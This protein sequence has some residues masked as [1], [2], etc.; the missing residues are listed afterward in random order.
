MKHEICQHCGYA[1]EAFGKELVTSSHGS[2]QFPAAPALAPAAGAELAVVD[3]LFYEDSAGAGHCL[4]CGAHC[5]AKW[6]SPYPSTMHAFFSGFVSLARGWNLLRARGKL[7]RRL[8]MPP[9]VALFSYF[10]ILLVGLKLLGGIAEQ[11]SAVSW[12]YFDWAR[13]AA[14]AGM[15]AAFTF[16]MCV[17][18]YLTFAPATMAI[19]GPFLDPVVKDVDRHVLGQAP[20]LSRGIVRDFWLSLS[21]ALGML[22]ISLGLTILALPLNL[23][24]ILGSLLYLAVV[25]SLTGLQCLDVPLGRRQLRFRD[26]L[27]LARANMG[28]T[29]GLGIA[30]Y[31]LF[32]VPIVGWLVG[33]QVSTAG[34]SLVAFR[35]R[36]G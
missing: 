29:L 34:A 3:A 19:A 25:A 13:P 4:V 10:L 8:I 36:K 32:L 1:W 23:V 15:G 20:E 11:L 30:C 17:F 31:L 27:A 33:P 35:L 6:L 26:R 24:P 2:R 22:A 12:G 14:G 18:A 21:S 9:A 7:T 16:A 28:A 5:P